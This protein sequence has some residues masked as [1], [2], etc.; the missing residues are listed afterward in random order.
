MEETNFILLWEEQN[1]K[2][3]KAIALNRRLLLDNIQ[4]KTRNTLQS[5]IRSKAVGIGI[6][7][8]YLLLLGVPLFYAIVYYKPAA[9]YFIISIGAIFLIN[10]KA[11]FDYIK[12]IVL[13]S[14]IDYNGSVMEIQ[15][16]LSR[17][18]LAI[19]QHGRTMFL[20]LPFWTTF[21]LSSSWF[22]SKTSAGLVIMQVSITL[23]FTLLAIFLY[24]SLTIKNMDKKWVRAIL[25]GAGGKKVIS[26]L[27]FYKEM[28]NFRDDN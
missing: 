2:I 17:I 16:K 24:R 7:V 21:F 20:Q 1:K 9:N 13:A 23:A 8:L 19:M 26:A 25:S 10:L 28:E 11:L 27:S 12:H 14:G 5:L 15:Q 18:H 22:P 3:D 6:A 4:Q